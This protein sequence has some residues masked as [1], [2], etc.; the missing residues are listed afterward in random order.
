[1]RVCW[2]HF[3]YGRHTITCIETL[4]R[5][6]LDNDGR[7]YSPARPAGSPSTPISH[8]RPTSR[9][10]H[11]RAATSREP[12][13]GSPGQWPVRDGIRAAGRRRP[14]YRR[15]SARHSV[16]AGI[17]AYLE[18]RRIP[19]R[20]A[21]IL[22]RPSRSTGSGWTA[23]GGDARRWWSRSRGAAGRLT[24]AVA[25]AARLAPDPRRWPADEEEAW[26]A[27]FRPVRLLHRCHPSVAAAEDLD[28]QTTA[29]A[30]ATPAPSP[31]PERPPRSRGTTCSTRSTPLDGREHRGRGHFERRPRRHPP[32]VEVCNPRA[33][34]RGRWSRAAVRAVF[35]RFQR[36]FALGVV[37]DYLGLVLL[38]WRLKEDRDDGPDDGADRIGSISR[39]SHPAR[40]GDVRLTVDLAAFHPGPLR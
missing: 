10:G 5:R 30:V 13:P 9:P 29:P 21:G 24:S 31:S 35:R 32:A 6:T 17:P 14:A 38:I 22:P 3:Q 36:L 20:P 4:P 34:A 19:T 2:W 18:R 15:P 28:T 40:C 25:G 39:V 27:L 16:A 26:D 23:N 8:E 11:D 12:G 1:M 7:R 33:G 37:R